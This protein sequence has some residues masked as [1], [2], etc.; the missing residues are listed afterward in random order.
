MITHAEEGTINLVIYQQVGYNGIC[1][2]SKK[3]SNHFC[4]QEHNFAE[5]DDM[6]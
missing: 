2:F 5:L 6:T 1:N 3:I 4:M